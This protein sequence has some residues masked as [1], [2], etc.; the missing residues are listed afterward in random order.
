MVH[1]LCGNQRSAFRSWP[2]A[3]RPF[4]MHMAFSWQNH[5]Q[6]AP[7]KI[8]LRPAALVRTNLNPSSRM[9]ITL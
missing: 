4:A 8:A 9:D 6:L 3:D 5:A 1:I 7:Y 2:I